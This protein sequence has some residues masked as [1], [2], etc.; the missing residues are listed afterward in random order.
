[1]DGS[2]LFGGT[3]KGKNILDIQM[4]HYNDSIL[5]VEIFTEDGSKIGE[6]DV[7][8][9]HTEPELHFYEHNP[10]R[11]LSERELVSPFRL[12]SEETT[13][14][15]EPFFIDAHPT[16]KDA[17][18]T[19]SLNNETIIQDTPVPNALTLQHVGGGSESTIDLRVITK[20][21]IPQLVTKAFHVIFE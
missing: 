14:Y 6:G 5:S 1:M 16:G 19:W 11:G 15:G 4:P 9:T 20:K 17:T 2:A 13:L 8:L 12:L 3:L 18:Y 21:T 7:L 10:L